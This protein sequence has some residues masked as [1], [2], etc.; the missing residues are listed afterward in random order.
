MSRVHSRPTILH[1]T[2]IILHFT[3]TPPFFFF[4]L[5]KNRT[6]NFILL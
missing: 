3:L 5:N 2:F 4:N 1:F 6:Y